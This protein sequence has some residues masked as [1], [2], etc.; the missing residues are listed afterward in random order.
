MK[1]HGLFCLLF[2]VLVNGFFL[3]CATEGPAEGPDVEDN[4]P[5][6][7]KPG[8]PA[9]EARGITVNPGSIAIGKNITAEFTATFTEN[10]SGTLS[11]SV[12]SSVEG[13]KVTPV[14]GKTNVGRL[15]VDAAETAEV[16]TVKAAL[17]SGNYGTAIVLVIGN[18]APGEVHG[19]R[20]APPGTL[21]YPGETF[22]FKAYDAENGTMP[23]EDVIWKVSG[24]AADTAI[25]KSDGKLKIA[26]GETAKTLTVTA[27]KN[28]HYGTAKVTV[29]VDRMGVPIPVN[30]EIYV[31]ANTYTVAEGGTLTF[32]AYK[33]GNDAAPLNGVTWDVFGGL[34]TDTKIGSGGSNA[35]KLSVAVGETTK[36]LTVKASTADGKYGTAVV[37]VSG[38]SLSGGSPSKPNMV[39]VPGGTFQ[40]GR[41]AGNGDADELPV[42]Q[43]TV[44]SFWMGSHEVTQKEWFDVMGT[45]MSDQWTLAR[46]NGDGTTMPNK[47]TGDDYPMYWV[48]WGEAVAYCNALSVKEKLTPAYAISGNTVTLNPGASGYRLPTEAEWEYAAKEGGVDSFIYSGSDTEKDVAW[49][50]DNSDGKTQP[51]KGKKP[52]RLG[53]YDMSGNVWE[54][55][56][57]LYGPYP[58]GPVKNPTGPSSGTNRVRRGGSWGNDQHSIR[59]VDRHDVDPSDRA[60]GHG[61]RVVCP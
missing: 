44:D 37:K 25:G 16:L 17:D 36:Y 51:V 24:G 40:M 28:E 18:E 49:Y 38:G 8:I 55:C 46:K 35:G 56:W 60:D 50:K 58:S 61:F 4:K 32:T 14:E 43:V 47:G 48:T 22:T 26:I 34:K 33:A 5:L 19:I 42:H 27:T 13:T 45:T 20:V 31:K 59:T 9:S 21:L 7:K 2:V 12:D 53:L 29:L 39:Y 57:D 52:N 3:S 23:L 41:T 1:K 11:W 10:G 6:T 54:W 30:N 15:T